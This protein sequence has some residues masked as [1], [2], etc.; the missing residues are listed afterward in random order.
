M[1][2]S[3]ID[4]F[5]VFR[6]IRG[7]K[8]N[9]NFTTENTEYTEESQRPDVILLDA[10]MIQS[11]AASGFLSSLPLKFITRKDGRLEHSLRIAHHPHPLSD[12]LRQECVSTGLM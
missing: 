7:Q 9:R 8:H 1:V 12:L 11:F 4:L 10:R 2:C 3:A 6:V 5:R